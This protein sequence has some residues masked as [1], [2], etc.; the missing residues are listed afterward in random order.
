LREDASK[1]MMSTSA[2]VAEGVWERQGGGRV[3]DQQV[4]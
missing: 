3:Y 4:G 1:T 2:M